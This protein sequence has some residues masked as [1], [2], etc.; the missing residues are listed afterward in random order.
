VLPNN[1]MAS[2]VAL[3]EL[4]RT[5]RV[6]VRRQVE[7]MVFYRFGPLVGP[8]IDP[9]E[10]RVPLSGLQFYFGDRLRYSG[11]LI[12]ALR[13]GRAGESPCFTLPLTVLHPLEGA[14]SYGLHLIDHSGRLVAQ[15]DAG[16]G[17]PPAG[18]TQ[19]LT[20]CLVLPATLPLGSYTVQLAV[21]RWQDGV[22]LRV[23]ESGAAWGDALV[24][25][26]VEI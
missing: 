8:E 13:T 4:S 10:K 12:A 18:L 3:A 21:Y 9:V 11:D 20:P 24:V 23:L 15:V 26:V 17:D 2:W 5:R 16:L 7:Y 1:T 6:E 25:A 19:R 14:Y 22:R